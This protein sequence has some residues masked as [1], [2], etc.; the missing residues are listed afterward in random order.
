VKGKLGSSRRVLMILLLCQEQAASVRGINKISKTSTTSISGGAGFSIINEALN[1]SNG[2]SK[3]VSD[4]MDL[5]GDL[6]PD[7]VTDK[8]VQY[9]NPTGELQTTYQNFISEYVT[10]TTTNSQARQLAVS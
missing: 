6:T 10:S 2:Q 9:T 5:N 1:T 4:F 3:L 7:I 8:G